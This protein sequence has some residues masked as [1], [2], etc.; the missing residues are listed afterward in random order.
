MGY[1]RIHQAIPLRTAWPLREGLESFAGEY[2]I[3]KEP[4][5][6]KYRSFRGDA[7]SHSQW[8]QAEYRFQDLYKKAISGI[9]FESKNWRDTSDFL[10][11]N[12]DFK[13]ESTQQLTAV[14]ILS[15]QF[16]SDIS[17][18]HIPH[19]GLFC[20]ELIL[21]PLSEQ[22]LNSN[23][24]QLAGAVCSVLPLLSH[25]HSAL[26]KLKGQKTRVDSDILRSITAYTRT[27][28]MLWQQLPGSRV[29]P[30]LPLAKQYHPTQAIENLPKSEYF[31]GKILQFENY[32]GAV[33]CLGF[34]RIANLDQFLRL[35][36]K[37]EWIRYQ[38]HSRIFLEDILRE[39][40]DILYRSVCEIA[41]EGETELC[42]D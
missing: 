12:Y 7:I 26:S 24:R 28:T 18:D 38:R 6:E 8:L 29:K 20:D 9:E 23:Y 31:I 33:L 36:L 4:D 22:Q 1:N 13:F 40:A 41:K 37:M 39:R 15:S 25:G 3:L 11:L 35:R 30:L 27:P 19:I 17:E 32:S 14:T 34:D 10:G 42:L 2:S 21:G 16:L 5:W